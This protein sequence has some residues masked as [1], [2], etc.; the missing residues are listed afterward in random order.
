M[1]GA[2]T[3]GVTR[4]ISVGPSVGGAGALSWALLLLL[5]S[6]SE[7]GSTGAKSKAIPV[8]LSLACEKMGGADDDAD[9]SGSVLLFVLRSCAC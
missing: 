9:D 3:P 5:L 6:A 2:A 1:G 8:G 4:R 7:P